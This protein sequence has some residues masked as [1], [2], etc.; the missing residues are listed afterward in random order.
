V[1]ASRSAFW[2]RIFGCKSVVIGALCAIAGLSPRLSS[3]VLQ[4]YAMHALL[5]VI[6]V[7]AFFAA[8]HFFQRAAAI[9]DARPTD[10]RFSSA[11][12]LS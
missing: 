10:D 7:G 12:L 3:D 5:L 4:S 11:D 9:D 6:A 8:R 2:N 1:I